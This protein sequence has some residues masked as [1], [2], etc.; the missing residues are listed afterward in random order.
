MR[1]RAIGEGG[2][3][4]VAL[5][6]KAR[7]GRVWVPSSVTD[8]PRR[9]VLADKCRWRAERCA[10]GRLTR[11]PKILIGLHRRCRRSS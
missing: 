6:E 4:L 3:M 8:L 10:R 5:I 2:G 1:E 11:H 9:I 7:L